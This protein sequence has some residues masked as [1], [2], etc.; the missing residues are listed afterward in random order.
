M[1]I[2]HTVH[3]S[4]DTSEHA[5]APALRRCPCRMMCGVSWW[6]GP[7]TP[8][9]PEPTRSPH[10]CCMRSAASS[11]LPRLSASKNSRRLARSSEPCVACPTGRVTGDLSR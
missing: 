11:S 3:T 10:T 5:M 1:G 4:Q 2:A 9:T 7:S 6:P 8:A